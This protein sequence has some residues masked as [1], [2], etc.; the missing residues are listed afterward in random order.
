MIMFVDCRILGQEYFNVFVYLK[1]KKTS[2]S[3]SQNSVELE[4][5]VVVADPGRLVLAT[6]ARA[7][8]RGRQR[9][10]AAQLRRGAAREVQVPQRRLPIGPR[11]QRRQRAVPDTT[12][13]RTAAAGLSERVRPDRAP[14]AAERAERI[15]GRVRLHQAVSRREATATRV[16][17][18]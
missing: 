11:R 10:V 17:E 7:L 16:P 12:A 9:G 6:R 4:C 13:Q 1:Q 18:R 15:H 5:E 14:D 3:R 2:N 8:V